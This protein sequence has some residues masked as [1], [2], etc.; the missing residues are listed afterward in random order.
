[1]STANATYNFVSLNETAIFSAAE[2]VVASILAA[3]VAGSNQAAQTGIEA[4]LVRPKFLGHRQCSSVTMSRTSNMH[5]DWQT[6]L[7]RRFGQPQ[8][9]RLSF[10][11]QR[12][13]RIPMNHT[14][15]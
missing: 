11:T 9:L 15:M 8:A 5:S 6:Q 1:M 3:L 12:F 2:G 14:P 7:Q 13:P 4:N 10:L